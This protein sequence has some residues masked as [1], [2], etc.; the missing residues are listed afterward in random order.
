MGALLHSSSSEHLNIGV[1][2]FG[3]RNDTVLSSREQG[4]HHPVSYLIILP[5][6]NWEIDLCLKEPVL[7]WVFCP[8]K[9]NLIFIIMSHSLYLEEFEPLLCA[10]GS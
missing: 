9:L 4:H 3:V 7:F 10:C 2:I 5:L 1:S 8:T 6:Y